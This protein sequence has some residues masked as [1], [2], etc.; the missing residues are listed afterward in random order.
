[1]CFCSITVF[2]NISP[3]R[4][5]QTI[6]SRYKAYTIISRQCVKHL[7]V[8]ISKTMSV[9]L[10]CVHLMDPQLLFLETH[11]HCTLLYCE[12]GFGSTCRD[13]CG[14]LYWLIWF[15]LTSAAVCGR[16]VQLSL[17]KKSALI[18]SSSRSSAYKIKSAV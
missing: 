3:L 10:V 11:E 7:C 18:P 4:H 6:L 16:R 17:R 9:K 15:N 8:F 5:C 1:M 14:G 12:S 2:F 13:R